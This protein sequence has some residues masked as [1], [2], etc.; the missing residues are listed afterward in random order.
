MNTSITS[1]SY[2]CVC[3]CVCVVRA[4]KIYSL[5]KFQVYDTVLLTMVTVLYIRSPELIHFIIKNL[6]PLTNISPFPAPLS[7]TTTILLF[8]SKSLTFLDS[9][10]LC[11]VVVFIFYIAHT[12]TC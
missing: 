11:L 8:S 5:S 6:Y 2:L 12:D 9:T 4:F 10:Y 7:L 1:L 3:V